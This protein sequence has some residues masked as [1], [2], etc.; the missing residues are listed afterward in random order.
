VTRIGVR[1]PSALRD[2]LKKKAQ[3]EGTTES[4]VARA[5][6]AHYLAG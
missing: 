3:E 2:K 5:A 1:L 6:I 4:Q